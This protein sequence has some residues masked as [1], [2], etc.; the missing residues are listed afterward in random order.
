MRARGSANLL[1]GSESDEKYRT[2]RSLALSISDLLEANG[3]RC[4]L[5]GRSVE[6]KQGPLDPGFAFKNSSQ[7]MRE[8]KYFLLLYPE[9]IVSTVL[10]EAGQATALGKRA[11]YFVRS[12]SDLPYSLQQSESLEGVKIYQSLDKTNILTLFKNHGLRAFEPW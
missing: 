2:I 12:R 10:V 8:A 7:A 6:S 9:R 5:P 1:Y 11:I 4:H 3:H